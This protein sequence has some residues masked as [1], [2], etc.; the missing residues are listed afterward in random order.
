MI[1]VGVTHYG[2]FWGLAVDRRFCRYVL[3]IS[4]HAGVDTLNSQ[5][6]TVYDLLMSGF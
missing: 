6:R 5:A 2:K 3:H 4:T 1:E